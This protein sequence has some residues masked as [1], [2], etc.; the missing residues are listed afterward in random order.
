MYRRLADLSALTDQQ[1]HFTLMNVATFVLARLLGI[2]LGDDNVA[3]YIDPGDTINDL[4]AV[5][6]N[7]DIFAV[8]LKPMM[9]MQITTPPQPVS[10]L[11]R[12]TVDHNST[13]ELK[14]STFANRA[15]VAKMAVTNRSAAASTKTK[16]KESQHSLSKEAKVST[17]E[18]SLQ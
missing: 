7:R 9:S 14:M 12:D 2:V 13:N 15:P 8:S 3:R 4:S 16:E 1:Q 17:G 18:L 10:H 6:K 5:A 11:M